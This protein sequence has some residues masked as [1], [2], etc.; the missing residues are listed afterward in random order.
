MAD[1]LLVV[2]GVLTLAVFLLLYRA[3]S[4]PGESWGG[5]RRSMARRLLFAVLGAAIS[6]SLTARW[7]PEEGRPSPGRGFQAYTQ[8]VYFFRMSHAGLD[9]MLPMG[10]GVSPRD[11]ALRQL[12]A[13]VREVPQSAHFH[14]TLG[15]AL[16]DSGDYTGARRE[17]EAAVAVLRLRA[18]ERAAAEAA[19]WRTLFATRP[20]PVDVLRQVHID[21]LRLGWLGDTALLAAWRRVPGREPPPEVREAVEVSARRYFHGVIVGGSWLVLLLPQLGLISLVVALLLIRAGVLRRAVFRSVASSAPLWESFILMFAL[22]MLPALLAPGGRP[23]PESAPALFGLLLLASDLCQ[24]LAVGY[25]WWRLRTGGFNLAEIGLSNR[26][27]MSNLAVGAMAATVVTP[28]AVLVGLATQF[29]S[30]RFFPNIA[31]PYHPLQGLTATSSGA[32]IRLAL[33]LAAVV[34]APLL[35]EIFFRGV[36]YGALR[37]RFGVGWGIAASAAFFAVLH[38]Q[39]PL[40]FLP[41]AFLGA[42]FAALYEWRQS[43]VPG[44]VAHAI[45]NGIVF[46]LL[47]LLFPAR[48]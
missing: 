42:A 19:V 2:R 29:L 37:R 23:A 20:P 15:I 38:P 47:N 8:G 10:G 12:R 1:G 9:A 28:A 35:E 26:H 34:G 25:L 40:G 31:P 17:L 3:L 14:R 11:R 4:D 7:T 46:G 36:L 5:D 39:L 27:L 41:I 6:F 21:D 43:L 32:E 16:A 48:G 33:F 24:L 13:A 18:P 30:D 45:N 44:M 22:G